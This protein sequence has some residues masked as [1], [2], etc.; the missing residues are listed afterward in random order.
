MFL[1]TKLKNNKYEEMKNTSFGPHLMFDLNECNVEK[2]N[3]YKFIYELLYN[4]PDMI[5]MTKITQPYV[6]PYSGLVP[7]DEG[8]TGIVIIAESHCSIHTFPKKN[9]VFIDIFSCKYFETE[10]IKNYLIN[11]FESKTYEVH[12]AERGKD[13]PR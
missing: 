7:E 1:W 12:F 5:G 9:Y 11:Q 6:F 3:D 13:F 4:I 8:I 2:L 10:E